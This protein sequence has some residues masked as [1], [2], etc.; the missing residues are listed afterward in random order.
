ML[1]RRLI[2]VLLTLLGISGCSGQ[3]QIGRWRIEVGP[4]GNEFYKAPQQKAEMPPPSEAVLRWAKIIAPHAKVTEWEVE[5]GGYRINAEVGKEKYQFDVTPAGQLLELEYENDATDIKEEPD[6][7]VLRGTKK[8]IAVSEVPK[9]TLKTLAEAL[10]DA[11]PSQTWTA[12]TIAGPRYVIVIDEMAFYARPDGQ[13]QAAGLISEGALD[14]I[15]P[16]IEQGDKKATSIPKRFSARL[17]KLLGPYRQRFNFENQIKRL[18]KGPKSA[19]GSFR[20]V[21]MGDSRSQWQLWSNIIKHIDRLEPKPDF[22]INVGD[23]VSKGYAR[24]YYQYYIPPLLKTDI[25]FFVA[26][27]NHDDGSDSMAQEYQYLFGEKTLNYYFDY[28]NARYIFIDNVTKVQPYEQTL[29]WLDKTLADTPKGYR[30]YVAAHKPPSTIEKWAYHAWDES[31]SRAFTA[32][33]T[34]HKVDEVYL[35]H[36]HAYSTARYNGVNYTVSGGGG[37]GLHDRYGPLGNVHHY[38]ICDVTADGTVKQQV[39][40]FYKVKD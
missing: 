37:A 18:G 3:E 20:Y 2:V 30:K 12:E 32:L 11:K 5:N 16:S 15:E 21:V 34:K 24:Q 29:E 28:G 9:A 36:I 23:V 4:P 7:L 33:M 38:V 39:V 8:S 1:K 26:I 19:D 27:G 10:P 40:R 17:E 13:I 6:E 22:V 31:N 25:P 14:E 35:G